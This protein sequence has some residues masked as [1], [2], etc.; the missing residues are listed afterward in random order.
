MTEFERSIASA[1][2]DYFERNDIK[3]FAY[4]KRQAKYQSQIVDV[5]VDSPDIGYFAIECKSLKMENSKRLNFKSDFSQSKKGH[6]IPVVTTFS[7]R[8]GRT[9]ALAVEIRKGRGKPREAHIYDW[10]K[11][12]KLYKHE[13]AKSV[14]P[15]KLKNF[16]YNVIREGSTY[17]L[18][19]NDDTDS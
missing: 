8:T 14:E 19:D 3:G 17:E 4:R 7:D 1:F 15:R 13:R 5:L 11:V 18:V 10:G 16:R 2:N 9:P 6:Q 12:Y